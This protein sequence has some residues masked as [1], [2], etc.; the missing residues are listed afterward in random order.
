MSTSL[1]DQLTTFLSYLN[2][3]AKIDMVLAKQEATMAAIDDLKAIV[4]KLATDVA[5]ELAALTAA[6]ASGDTA[7][8]EEAVA[9]L[10]T[11]SN[12]LESS[13]APKSPTP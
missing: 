1:L 2:L 8:I 3:P 7:A 4:A 13:V 10:T 6:Q 9:N 11:L 12:Q 5:A